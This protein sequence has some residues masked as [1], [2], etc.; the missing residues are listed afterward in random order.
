MR[1]I[2]HNVILHCL[3]L[4]FNS[5]IQGTLQRITLSASLRSIKMMLLDLLKMTGII[6][7]CWHVYSGKSTEHAV[8]SFHTS[9]SQIML[10]L[11]VI[12]SNYCF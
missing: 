9:D 2:A 4:H 11:L 12:Q 10:S 8:N 3:Y 7:T 5:E 6:S 1:C